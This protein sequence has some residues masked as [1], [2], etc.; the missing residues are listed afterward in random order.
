MKDALLQFEPVLM[1]GASVGSWPAHLEATRF[2]GKVVSPSKNHDCGQ[3]EVAQ[4]NYVKKV[5][6]LGSG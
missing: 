3:K 4:I 1:L 5:K 6:Q 2:L